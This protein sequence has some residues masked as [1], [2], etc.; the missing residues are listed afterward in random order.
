[1]MDEAPSTLDIIIF[2][3]MTL[4]NMGT[5]VETPEPDAKVSPCTDVNFPEN[6]IKQLSC[7]A[8]THNRYVVVNVVTKTPCPD[9]DMTAN[10]DPRDCADRPDGFSY[11]NTNI[12]FDRSGTVI[13]RYRKYNLFGEAVDKP[14]KPSVVAFDTDFGVRFGHF[15]CFD[16]MFRAPAL[17]LVRRE[18]ITDIIFT[19]M[20]FSEMPFLTAVQVQQNWAY[21]NNV[22]FLAAG[23][24][25]PAVGSTGTGIFAAR[26]GSLIS[27]M[28]GK[29][30]TRLYT[31]TVPKRNFT[32]QPITETYVRYDKNEMK[33]LKLKRDQL[34]KYAIQFR[35]LMDGERAGTS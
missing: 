33:P 25:N 11:Y 27:V 31:A 35:K 2:P 16:L 18:N 9:A 19:T 23:A 34:D 32:Q 3:E 29:A 14:H 30:D 20:W 10:G 28:E 4:N 8:R 17:E 22:N 6:L 24:N 1:M 15:V 21:T 5:A 26:Q 13:S 12:V 7:S